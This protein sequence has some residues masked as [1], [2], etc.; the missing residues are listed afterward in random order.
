MFNSTIRSSL[1]ILL[2]IL[3]LS[4]CGGGSGQSLPP[5]SAS[6]FDNTQIRDLN[7]ANCSFTN[8]RQI[9]VNSKILDVWDISYTS[10]EYINGT[11]LTNITIKGY[12]AKPASISTNIPA[13]V[14]AHGLGD[15]TTESD[16]AGLASNLDMFVLSY[17]GP[18]G[19]SGL[20]ASTS[21]G[22]PSSYNNSYR[23]FDTLED[24]RGSWFWAHTVA[25]MRGLTCLSAR[26]EVDSTRLGMTGNSAGGIATLLAKYVDDRIVAAVPLSST[27]NFDTSVESSNSWFHA[28][29]TVAGLTT[30]STEWTN[31]VSAVNDIAAENSASS[32]AIF[33]INGSLDEFFPLPAHRNTFNAIP[34]TDKR[35]SFIGNYDHG[36]YTSGIAGDS[37]TA[38]GARAYLRVSGGQKAW[39]QH[40]FGTNANYTI[41][42]IAPSISLTPGGGAFTNVEVSADINP[43]ALDIEEVRVWWSNDNG[44]TF[45]SAVLDDLGSGN[46]SLFAGFPLQANTLAY[47]DVQY[48]TQDLL[49]PD[50]FSVSSE[51]VMP[52]DFVQTVR[53]TACTI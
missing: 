11:G 30:T 51:L 45:T 34:G 38:I 21:E 25:A 23:I 5:V 9:T 2:V 27:L 7:T 40:W 20:A 8:P 4:S 47:A 39:F 16:A 14:Y 44:V 32:S 33:M 1:M 15:F 12:A 24:N 41:L 18:G 43:T 42:P 17:T 46:Y 35:S 28:L 10:W 53:T 13:L 36:C 52:A 49:T 6:L 50:R 3:T 26:S 48:K 31:L 37:A 22:F 19:D 29:L